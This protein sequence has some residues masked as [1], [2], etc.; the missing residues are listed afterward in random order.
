MSAKMIGILG[1]VFVG[2]IITLIV[3]KVANDDNKSQTK[4]DERQEIVR[5]KGY[6][7]GYWT[8]IITMAI[9][10]IA[11]VMIEDAGIVLPI[12]ISLL[13]FIVVMIGVL[14]FAG[15]CIFN[16]GYFGLNNNR[17]TYYILFF[18]IGL[19]NL[20]LGIYPIIS[21]NFIEKNGKVGSNGINLVCGISFVIL[22]IM[23]VIKAIIDKASE[24]SD[25]TADTDDEM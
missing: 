5:G 21:G 22:G 8:L 25:D 24:S 9:L 13:I 10:I 3:L 14:V 1:G 15:Y 11:L 17:R 2:L 23:L 4:Y 20:F 7:I 18:I 6:K 16:D 19:F 12:S